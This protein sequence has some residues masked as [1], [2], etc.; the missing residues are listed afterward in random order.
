M[1]RRSHVTQW[2]RILEEL[3]GI[4]GRD[5]LKTDPDETAR[6]AVDGV[7]PKAVVFPKD[8]KTTAAIMQ[9]ASRCNLAVAP[10]GSGTKTAMGPPPK[11]L[12]LVLCMARM[13]HMLDVDTANLTITVEAGVK[14]RD[15]QARLA[16][17][18]DRCYLPL[19]DLKTEAGEFVCSDRSHSGCFFPLDPPFAERAT[20]GGIIATNSS[21]PRRL[22]YGL[23]RD[24]LLG[25]RFVSPKGEII[26]AGGKT[27]KNVSGY[28]ISKLM[29]GALGTLGIL[30]EMT[31]RL[32]PLPERM[33]TLVFS[34]DSFSNASAF[35]DAVL[36]TKLL[37]AALEV[38]DRAALDLMDFRA[39]EDYG[40]GAYAVMVALEGFDEAVTRMIKEMQ[41]VARHFKSGGN[42]LVRE[43]KHRL[44][45]LAVGEL[46][47][48][49]SERSPRLVALRL[50]Y[51]LSSWKAVFEAA[52]RTLSEIGLERTLLCHSGSGVTLVNILLNG[53]GSR[54][55]A[56]TDAVGALLAQCRKVGGNLIV[57]RAPRDLKNALPV[58]GEPGPD[59]PL[60][61]KIRLEV[62]PSC[63]IN[64][65]RSYVGI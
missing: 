5:R 62:D 43:D 15:V 16:T 35:A 11:H 52:D 44:F 56:M 23:P 58:W 40:P 39:S 31:V 55:R 3:A 22:L 21:G 63:L 18:E 20:M 4:A 25:V 10:W 65:G 2:T 47:A 61:K 60:M 17:E 6:Y 7:V 27:V 1:T 50:N 42:T 45:W 13:N 12:D 24:L 54:E 8:T 41:A 29:I 14:L 26:G 53:E 9:C 49:L 36:A 51:P 57:E 28:D 59:L 37:P 38:A 64:P 30:C 34:F 32:L 33:E 48:S 46:Q 19:E